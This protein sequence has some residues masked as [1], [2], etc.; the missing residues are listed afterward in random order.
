MLNRSEI[1]LSACAAYRRD[2]FKGWAVRRGEAFNR[3][4]FAHCLSMAWAVAKE[5]KAVAAASVERRKALI[6]EAGALNNHPALV[7]V[8]HVSIMGMMDTAECERHV[9]RLRG[10]TKPKPP[11]AVA[12]RVDAIRS[13]LLDMQMG[14]FIPW[15]RHAALSSELVRIS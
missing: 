15:A 1:L 13:E 3:R 8:D 4:H 10:M 5:V 9:A 12:A 2:V 11:A 14:D 6:R 7:N